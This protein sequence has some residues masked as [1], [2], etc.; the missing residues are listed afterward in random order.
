[1]SAARRPARMLAALTGSLDSL[2][3]PAAA[4]VSGGPMI[5]KQS[6]MIWRVLN[7]TH[8]RSVCKVNYQ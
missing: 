7:E 6:V 1:M 2:P 3:R 5:F 8:A 4:G